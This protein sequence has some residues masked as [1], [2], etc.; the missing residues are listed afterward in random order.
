[1]LASVCVVSCMFKE[2]DSLTD[3]TC[4]VEAVS[5][6]STVALNITYAS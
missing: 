5:Q 3:E 6:K 1:M 2:N 4:P